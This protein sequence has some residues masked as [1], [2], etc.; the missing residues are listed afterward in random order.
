MKQ[1]LGIIGIDLEVLA[2]LIDLPEGYQIQRTICPSNEYNNRPTAKFVIQGPE[3]PEIDDGTMIP[4]LPCWRNPS[5]GQIGF[6]K[7]NSGLMFRTKSAHDKKRMTD[8][9]K[10]AKASQ[11]L[12][13]IK[14][15]PSHTLAQLE[16]AESALGKALTKLNKKK[17]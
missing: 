2:K 4:E 16:R 8:L 11:N 12:F 6:G 15:G 5:K 1:N 17:P 10:V 14:F 13:D 9:E 7:I 3:M